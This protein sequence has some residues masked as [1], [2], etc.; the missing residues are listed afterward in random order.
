MEVLTFLGDRSEVNQSL[1]FVFR[2]CIFLVK[3]F[4]QEYLQTDAWRQADCGRLMSAYGNLS[5]FGNSRFYFEDDLFG[6]FVINHI[7]IT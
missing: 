3:S 1:L 4:F 2:C 6:I 5:P 7:L